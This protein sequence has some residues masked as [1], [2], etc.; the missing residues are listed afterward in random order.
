MVGAVE[1][2]LRRDG[3]SCRGRGVVGEEVF[4]Y[5][6]DVRV[7]SGVIAVCVGVCVVCSYLVFP[8]RESV[9]KLKGFVNHVCSLG[10]AIH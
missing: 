4:C 9:V 1:D 3:V 8:G 5:G 6:P 10:V 2:G 7:C